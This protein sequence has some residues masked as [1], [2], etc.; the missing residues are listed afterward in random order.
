[1]RKT[2]ALFLLAASLGSQLAA[3][4]QR[5]CSRTP[6]AVETYAVSLGLGFQIRDDV[7]DLTDRSKSGRP[8]GTDPR[9]GL[10][11]WP[12]LRW[13]LLQPSWPDAAA[14]LQRCRGN[15]E[16]CSKLA[17][18]VVGA[19]RLSGPPGRLIRKTQRASMESK[20]IAGGPGNAML[21][22]VVDG[23]CCSLS[24]DPQELL[25]MNSVRGCKAYSAA[26]APPGNSRDRRGYAMP[27]NF[28]TRQF[29]ASAGNLAIATVFL[30]P[31]S[32]AEGAVAHLCR[33]ALEACEDLAGVRGR[34]RG[35]L[36][37]LHGLPLGR[38]RLR[39]C[40]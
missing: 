39:A 34:S 22:E 35:P 5:F 27:A 16:E 2:G 10:C 26:T 19:A 32:R 25:P 7:L 3:K 33:R 30:S 38:H 13:A 29:T 37:P 40:P 15:D 4:R 1:M 8:A 28:W 6:T 14:R 11:S 12:V 9:N 21:G 23:H 18:D 31:A 20:R 17:R 36:A 24:I